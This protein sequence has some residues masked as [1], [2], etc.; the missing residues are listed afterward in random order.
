MFRRNQH[1]RIG[2]FGDVL[3]NG[4]VQLK[5]AFFIEQHDAQGG[6]RLAHRADAEDG[7]GAHG[8]G[9]LAILATGRVEPNNLAVTGDEGDSA[10]DFAVVDA[11]LNGGGDAL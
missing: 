7:I 5:A 1:F 3:G 10:G 11:L 6:N 8:L 9:V 4:V 2:E